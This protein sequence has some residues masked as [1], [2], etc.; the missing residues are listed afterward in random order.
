MNQKAQ[1][2]VGSTTLP[3][4]TQAQSKQELWWGGFAQGGG[5]RQLDMSAGCLVRQLVQ[6]EGQEQVYCLLNS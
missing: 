6:V 2:R 4:K 5:I 3:S 1:C